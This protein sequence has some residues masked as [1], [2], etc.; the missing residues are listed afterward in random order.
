[1]IL[2]EKVKLMNRDTMIDGRKEK[3]KSK[4]MDTAFLT[5]YNKQY[6]SL[7]KAVKKHWPS[8]Q[9]DKVLKIILPQQSIFIYKK[10]LSLRN[11]H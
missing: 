5:S 11:S 6:K 7:E 9:S 1:M 10:A 8:L 4:H 3:K 2:K